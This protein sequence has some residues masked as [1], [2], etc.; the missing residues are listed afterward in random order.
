MVEWA[1]LAVAFSS[2]FHTVVSVA[3]CAA[4]ACSM[5]YGARMAVAGWCLG[6]VQAYHVV[7]LVAVD[8][9]VEER[10]DE[11][12]DDDAED[13]WHHEDVVGVDEHVEGTWVSAAIV[14]VVVAG[15][16]LLHV[17]AVASAVNHRRPSLHA[18]WH[19]SSQTHRP[20]RTHS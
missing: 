11:T 3:S 19:A 4:V 20:C 17:A 6:S 15:M 8:D 2:S 12:V 18:Q 14:A 13:A 10:Y 16:H 9:D 5:A 7:V 1:F